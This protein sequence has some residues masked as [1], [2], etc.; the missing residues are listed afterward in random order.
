[1]TDT[2]HNL[3]CWIGCGVGYAT[4]LAGAALAA[5]GP[6]LPPPGLPPP[7]NQTGTRTDAASA[8]NRTGGLGVANPAPVR[9]LRMRVTAYCPC[10]KCCGKWADGMTAS[11]GRTKPARRKCCC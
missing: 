6:G 9:S 10:E 1:M 7:A 2:T 3:A 4:I 5:G 8:G 11:A